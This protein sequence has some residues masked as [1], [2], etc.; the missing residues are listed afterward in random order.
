M[1]TYFNRDIDILTEAKIRQ[2]CDA[3]YMRRLNFPLNRTVVN[4]KNKMAI[5]LDINFNVC[6][7]VVPNN[8]E[9]FKN[10]MLPYVIDFLIDSMKKLLPVRILNEIGFKINLY[11]PATSSAV[12]ETWWNRHLVKGNI[13][14]DTVL[15]VPLSSSHIKLTLP[16]LLTDVFT[17]QVPS[18][19][20]TSAQADFVSAFTAIPAQSFSGFATTP[21]PSFAGFGTPAQQN[22]QPYQSFSD[23]ATQQNSQPSFA[24]F[25]TPA[26]QTQPAQTFSGFGA[27]NQQTQPAQTF[28]GFGASSF[29]GFGNSSST[30][31]PTFSG[32]GLF[33]QNVTVPS[34]FTFGC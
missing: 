10:V 31:S 3:N 32:F 4:E 21:Q 19:P 5:Q 12:A 2:E 20:V 11:V 30:P 24:G 18:S 13:S 14:N 16:L 23:F 27:T 7:I 22:P 15:G 28:S 33:N 8:V 29:S 34:N 17:L 9:I 26:Q 25:G 1:Q 6:E